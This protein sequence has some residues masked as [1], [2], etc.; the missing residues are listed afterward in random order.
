MD[1]TCTSLTLQHDGRTHGE[2]L[3]QQ[4][5]AR[6]R[7]R[8]RHLDQPD[9]V[10]VAFDAR[11]AGMQIGLVLEE[12]EMAPFFLDGVVNGAS[13]GA[14]IGLGAAETRTALEI[15]KDIEPFRGR[16][17]IDGFDKP[18]VG[19]PEGGLKQIGVAQRGLQDRPGRRRHEMGPD[20]A[21]R[22]RSKC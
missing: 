16:V 18:R 1:W 22:V 12:I 5:E 4:R 15:E 7:P 6:A 20:V 9:A 17:E 21:W 3:E 13:S 2:R 14:A 10:R 19:Q 8:P 11:R